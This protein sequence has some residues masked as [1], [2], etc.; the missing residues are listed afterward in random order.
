MAI[1]KE[2]GLRNKELSDLLLEGKKF[3]DWV[4]TTAFYSSI[5]FVEDVIF[6]TTINA[7]ECKNISDVRK[8]YNANGRHESR[9]RLVYEKLNPKVGVRYKWLDDRSR[10]C[11]YETYKQTP[12]DALKAQ[13]YLE[14][15]KKFC[16]PD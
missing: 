8:A 15:I 13:E 2:W 14:Y 16:Y 11:R 6:P 9:E 7:C 3:Y 5:H 12:A 10:F 4:V 1:K